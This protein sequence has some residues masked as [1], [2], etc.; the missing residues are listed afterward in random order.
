[1]GIK[2]SKHNYHHFRKNEMSIRRDDVFKII[3]GANIRKEYL[4]DFLEAILHQNITDI[5]VKNE[6]SLEQIHSKSKLIRVDLLVEIDKNQ[7]ADI[8]IQN[9]LS[10]N[11][12]KRRASSCKQDLL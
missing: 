4:K 7:R 8:E 1:M 10:Y 11:I 5:K 6:V 2:L 12:I 3:F 9:Y